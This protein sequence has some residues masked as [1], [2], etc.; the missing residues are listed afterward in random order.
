MGVMQ[1]TPL[2]PDAGF[3]VEWQLSDECEVLIDLS[4]AESEV[5]GSADRSVR[6]APTPR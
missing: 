5:V 6:G 3:V 2:P 1:E 4:T